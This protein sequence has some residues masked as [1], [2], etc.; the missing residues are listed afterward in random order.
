MTYVI[1]QNCCNDA[2]CVQACPVGCIHPTP[3]EPGYLA[4]EMLYID[5]DACIDCAACVDACPVNAVYAED[6]L[7][8]DLRAYLAVNADYYK[9]TPV[10]HGPVVIP[11]PPPLPP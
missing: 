2:S 11:D 4:A 10:D 3:E 9:G 6:E 5:P 7:P 1:T 8:Q